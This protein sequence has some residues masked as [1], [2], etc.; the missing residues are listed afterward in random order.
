MGYMHIG[1]LYKERDILLFRRCYAMEKIHGTSAHV[2]WKD[3]SLRFFAGGA[4]HTEFVKL[5]DAAALTAA[6]EATGVAEAT[7][8]GEAYGGKM[9]AMRDIYGPDLRFVAFEVKIG[10]SF[11]AVPKAEGFA[12][13]L[14]FEFVHYVEVPT[15]LEALD[16]E[17]DADS[18]QAIRNGCGPGKPR[19]GVVLRPLIEVRTNNGGRV[20]AK[21]KRED[22]RET[23]TPRTVKAD[24]LVAL[25][26][27]QGIADEWVTEMRLTHV[28]DAFPGAGIQDTG[29]VIM[30]MVEDINR[31]AAGEIVPSKEADRAIRTAAAMMFKRRL[32]AALRAD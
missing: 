28:L 18:V 30:A 3:N 15:D 29:K 17:R 23:A 16:A 7:I 14:D 21:H 26:G 4:S 9:Q 11:L 1:N 10:D 8:Y 24:K 32:N 20:V 5:F 19:E 13:S 2:A 31:E 12:R 25:A 22:F 27:A 6:F